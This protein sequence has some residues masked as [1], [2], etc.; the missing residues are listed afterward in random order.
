V[1]EK[2]PP[3]KLVLIEGGSAWIP[4]LMWRFDTEFKGLRR[5]VPWLQRLPSE[6][7]AE[8]V[9][10]TTQPLEIAPKREN[11]VELLHSMGLEDRLVYSSDYPHWDADEIE[12]LSTRL[13][14]EWH[15]RVFVDNACALYG[16]KSADL[17]RPARAA[18]ARP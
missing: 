15:A 8:H 1:F 2:F 13:P 18:A 9:W 6:Y 5:E 16:W 10:V 14:A 11:V 7:F 12:Y 3:L 4:S 17:A